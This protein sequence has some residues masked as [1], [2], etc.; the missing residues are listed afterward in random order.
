MARG[1]IEITTNFETEMGEFCSPSCVFCEQIEQGTV[2]PRFAELWPGIPHRKQVLAQNKELLVVP[3]Y[4][5]IAQDHLLIITRGH[6]LSLASTPLETLL[7]VQQAKKDLEVFFNKTEP[8][9]TLLFFEHGPGKLNGVVQHCGACAGADHAHLHVVP[10]QEKQPGIIEFLEEKITET[11]VIPEI[12]ITNPQQMCHYA[13][14]PY[15]YIETDG[16]GHLFSPR[17][18]DVSY[19]PSQFIRRML[20]LYLKLPN[21]DW[22]VRHLHLEHRDLE[23]QRIWQTL[24]KFSN[25][26]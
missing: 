22:D 17:F 23:R 6:F 24:V 2:T 7:A 25:S 4:S 20:G 18:Q 1:S 14:Q 13:N 11:L 19:I 26:I 10:L 15:L 9:K 5:P 21:Q 8:D 16:L 12:E 3:D